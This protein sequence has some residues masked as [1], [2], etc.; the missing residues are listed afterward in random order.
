ML[1]TDP[2]QAEGPAAD[3]RDCCATDARIGRHFDRRLAEQT[4][5][6]VPPSMVE[7]SIAMLGL[8][9]DV[10]HER[11]RVLELG[12]GSGALAIALLEAGAT[13]VHGIDLSP[14]NVAA[15]RQRAADAGMTERAVFEA[16]DAAGVAAGK[17]DWVVLD[18]SLCCYAH[19]D[20]LVESAIRS[21]GRRICFS[22]PASRGWRGLVNRVGWTLENVPTWLLRR[23]CPTFVHDIG[24]IEAR[25]TAAG[26]TRRSDDAPGLW[27][28]AVFER[29]LR[30][31]DA[32][33]ALAGGA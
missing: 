30:G 19:V 14:A 5:N 20:V 8:L 28:V 22:V 31:R 29:D 6:G 15:A 12:C 1:G 32:A 24:R 10:A 7:V 21:A 25:L 13:S 2:K 27:Y 33:A 11:P 4:V 16:A 26:F 23:A 18:R 9:S 17:Y 3:G